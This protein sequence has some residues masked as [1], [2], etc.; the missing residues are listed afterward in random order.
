M[1]DTVEV[2]TTQ[3]AITFPM[4][5]AA[6]LTLVIVLTFLARQRAR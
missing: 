2:T 5:A 6:L 4:I 1:N 3:V